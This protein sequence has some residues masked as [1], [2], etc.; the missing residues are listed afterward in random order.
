MNPTI[1]L[2]VGVV[3]TAFPKVLQFLV[4]TL[5]ARILWSLVRR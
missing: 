5:L 4:A 3:L 1:F 2:L